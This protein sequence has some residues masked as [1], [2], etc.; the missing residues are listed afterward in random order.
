MVEIIPVEK[1]YKDV[2]KQYS[3]AFLYGLG[4]M[5]IGE[6]A[7]RLFEEYVNSPMCKK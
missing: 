7:L 4:L 3:T 6:A 2:S 5:V 1:I